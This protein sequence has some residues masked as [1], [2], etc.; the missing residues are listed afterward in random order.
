MGGW[1]WSQVSNFVR[2][3][4]INP[5]KN[6]LGISSPSKVFADEVGMQISAGIGEGIEAG[7]PDIAALLTGL[8]GVAGSGQAGGTMATAGASLGNIIVNVMFAGST[9]PSP[10]EAKA[11]GQAAGEGVAEALARR[12]VQLAAQRA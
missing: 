10:A 9:L 5:A 1:L 6:A 3:K 8:P 4:I 11:T 2:D 7:V 12:G